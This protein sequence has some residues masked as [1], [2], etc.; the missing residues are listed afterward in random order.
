MAGSGVDQRGAVR[1]AKG[2]FQEGEKS[3]GVSWGVGDSEWHGAS[4]YL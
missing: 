1:S 4:M 3:G 2:R